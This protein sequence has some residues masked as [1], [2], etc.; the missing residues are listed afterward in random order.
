MIDWFNLVVNTCWILGCAGALSAISYASWEASTRG[1]KFRTCVR[2]SHIQI[3]LNFGGFLFCVGLAG[4]SDVIWQRIL[5]V[6]LSVGFLI[7]I[8]GEFYKRRTDA[9]PPK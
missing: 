2:Q 9:K 3:A 1:E 5:W 8:G 6:V 4:A 7:Q